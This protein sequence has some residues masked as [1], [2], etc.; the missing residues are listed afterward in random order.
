[1][2]PENPEIHPTVHQSLT[3]VFDWMPVCA[4]ITDVH[5]LIQEVNQQ[6]VNFFRASTKEDFIFDKQNLTNLT[7]DGSRIKELLSNSKKTG[8]TVSKELFFRR[9]DKTISGA[10]VGVHAIP[11]NPS[12][13]LII[14][15]PTAPQNEVYVQE[16]AQS[17]KKEAQKFRPYLNKPGKLMLDELLAD[18]ITTNLH[19]TKPSNRY[20]SIIIGQDRLQ[21]IRSLFPNFSDKE[22]NLCAFL[23]LKMSIDEIAGA[24]GST[25]NSLRVLLHRILP[26]TNFT[27]TKEFIRFLELNIRTNS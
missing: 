7:I 22:L 26:K 2:L 17:F 25:P 23:S 9:F 6:T 24:T 21:I 12:L 16:L 3:A 13:F 18:D 27:D 19:S 1:M 20:S 8:K 15:H 4:I 10:T 5:G 11:E 14:F